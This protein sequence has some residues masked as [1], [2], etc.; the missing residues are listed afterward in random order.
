MPLSLHTPRQTIRPS[1]L[2]GSKYVS[3]ANRQKVDKGLG[4]AT[5]EN[6]HAY[7]EK[8]LYA[9]SILNLEDMQRTEDTWQTGA[10]TNAPGPSRQQHLRL[11]M[12]T[13]S[14]PD[15]SPPQPPPASSAADEA[16]ESADDDAEDYDTLT[17]L[18]YCSPQVKYSQR[19][20]HP[21]SAVVPAHIEAAALEYSS[22]FYT[23]MM[24]STVVNSTVE[25]STVQ[26]SIVQHSIVQYFTVQ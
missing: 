7:S 4:K 20:P 22:A 1:L 3:S 15:H 6:P 18:K 25:N 24:C 17:P 23:A 5:P 8:Q 11:N 16:S 19:Q 10:I 14:S 26:Y 2:I 12:L 13:A 9:L 21:E